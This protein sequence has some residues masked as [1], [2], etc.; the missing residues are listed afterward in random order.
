MDLVAA[1]AKEEGGQ[2]VHGWENITLK[3]EEASVPES[4]LISI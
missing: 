4:K 1:S 3:E 2:H